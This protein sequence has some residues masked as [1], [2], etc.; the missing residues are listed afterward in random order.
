MNPPVRGGGW[1][2]WW[3]QSWLLRLAVG[4][5]LLVTAPFAYLIGYGLMQGYAVGNAL[6]HLFPLHPTPIAKN[7]DLPR[8]AQRVT[9]VADLQDRNL[10]ES[11]GLTASTAA[12]DLLW[13]V[14]DSGN[15]PDLYAFDT[16]GASRG[17][18]RLEGAENVD[19]EALDS[20]VLDGNPYLIIGDVGDNFRWRDDVTLYLVREPEVLDAQAAELQESPLP[21]SVTARLAIDYPQGPRDCEALTVNVAADTIWLLSKRHYPPELYSVSLSALFDDRPA[22]TVDLVQELAHF[23]RPAEIDHLEVEQPQF[24]HTPTGMDFEHPWL[25]VTTYQHA[26]LYDIEHLGE[27]PRQIRLPSVGQREAISFAR[28]ND[29]VAYIT[30]ERFER[31]GVADL[32]KVEWADADT[33]PFVGSLVQ[34]PAQGTR[35]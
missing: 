13:S 20:F 9:W 26:L 35:R 31:R 22:A 3:P 16:T 11:S 18:W 15:H 4:L 17:T 25:L 2:K 6:V 19:W 10:S 27:I 21:L 23:P 1:R 28:N 7:P 5:L 34:T 32:F 30:R 14:N 24:R 33:D 29:K 8:V 12:D